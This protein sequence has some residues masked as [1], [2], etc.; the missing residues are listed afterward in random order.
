MIH[1]APRLFGLADAAP[2][3]AVAKQPPLNYV[4]LVAQ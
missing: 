1:S 2:F 3:S 4:M